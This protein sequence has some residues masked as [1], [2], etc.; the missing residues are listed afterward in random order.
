MSRSL[1]EEIEFAGTRISL[2]REEQV[3][4]HLSLDDAIDDLRDGFRVHARQQA[5]NCVR[6]RVKSRDSAWLHTLRAGIATWNVAGGK[7]YTSLGSDTP[8]MWATVID[9]TTGLP[10]AFVEANYLSRVRTAATTAIAT[11]LLAPP[12]V[13]CLA[14]FG[15]G[16]I[17]ELLVRAVL[18]VRPSVKRV[19]LVRH[20]ASKGTPDW[21]HQLG[22]EV[23]VEVRDAAVALIEADLVTTATNSRTPVIPPNAAM[24]GVRHINLVG[25]NHIRR[26][27][28][29]A[30]LAYQCLPP[31]GYLVVEDTSQARLEA[32]DFAAI[33]P[34]ILINW[35]SIPTLGQLLENDAEKEKASKA[36]LTAFKSVGIGLMDLAVAT[37]VL[38]RMGLLTSPTVS[39]DTASEVGD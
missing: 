16:K 19:S 39:E 9:T 34:E 38:R 21:C 3:R 11:D 13:T 32:G 2:I 8:S 28:I 5:V 10:L 14:H 24:P 31:D 15:V 6:L 26:Q 22:G 7:D 1:I 25:S 17:S 33:G 4:K 27:E 36:T 35:D 29:P 18:K 12:G 37:G 23:R 20:N 30:E